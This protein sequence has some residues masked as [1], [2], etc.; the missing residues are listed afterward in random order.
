M[1]YINTIN[2]NSYNAKE[3]E[4]LGAMW[5]DAQAELDKMHDAAANIDDDSEYEKMLDQIDAY[6]ESTVKP[7]YRRMFAAQFHNCKNNWF[8]SV[9]QGFK[10]D[11]E[12][13]IITARQ[14]D[15]FVKYACDEDSNSW[16]DGTSYCRC[17]GKLVTLYR[18]NALIAIKVVQL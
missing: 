7:A 13:H 12:R 17:D 2:N 18:H 10:A 14:Y 5:N 8:I 16:R 4:K 1:R 6:Y 3:R 9:I 15:C 11:N